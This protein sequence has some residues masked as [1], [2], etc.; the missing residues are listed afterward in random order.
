MIISIKLK[1][2]KTNKTKNKQTIKKKI[3]R[4]AEK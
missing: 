2:F 1:I 4:N 3:V